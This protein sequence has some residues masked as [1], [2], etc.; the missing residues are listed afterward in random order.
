VYYKKGMTQSALP[1]LEEIVRRE[2]NN[3]TF[4]YHLG[5]VHAAAG[6]D[7]KARV[8]LQQALKLNAKFD[9][10]EDARRVLATLVY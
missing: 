1:I 8:S 2:P 7:A 5:L 10:A 9:G 4:L 6:A 3:P